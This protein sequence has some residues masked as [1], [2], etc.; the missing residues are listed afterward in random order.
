[1]ASLARTDLYIDQARWLTAEGR[2]ADAHHLLRRALSENPGD[3]YLRSEMA[4]VFLTMG[5][6]KEALR[7]AHAATAIEP[8]AEWPRRLAA[9]AWLQVGRPRQ[10]LAAAEAA[11]WS[12]PGSA[13]ALKARFEA[14]LAL[15]LHEG[16]TETARLAR[17]MAPEDSWPR[18][19]QARVAALRSEVSPNRGWVLW[20]ASI[21]A[22]TLVVGA[23]GV[24][25]ATLGG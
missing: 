23:I 16:A 13:H 5:R 21:A 4:A 25:Q 10:A 7:E 15:G 19:D 1:M 24:A 20:A 14:Q 18:V 11:I 17:E 12:D 9:F 22:V 3:S 2:L 6:P 8:G